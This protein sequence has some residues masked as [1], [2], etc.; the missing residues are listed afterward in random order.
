MIFFHQNRVNPGFYPPGCFFCLAHVL[1]R[2]PELTGIRN[3]CGCDAGNSFRIKLR[4]F[5]QAVECDVHQDNQFVGRVDSLDV[6]GRVCF[7]QSQVLG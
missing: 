2:I 3:V 4:K 6:Q 5:E 1:D 7:G